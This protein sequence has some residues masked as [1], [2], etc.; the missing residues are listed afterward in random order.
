[1]IMPAT[2]NIVGQKPQEK[3]AMILPLEAKPFLLAATCRLIGVLVSSAADQ[4]GSY[5]GAGYPLSS[6]AMLIM[7]PRGPIFARPSRSATPTATSSVGI[8]ATPNIR[9]GE[10]AQNSASQSLNARMQANWNSLSGIMYM[11]S[12]RLV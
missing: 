4:S 10:A 11:V 2:V 3:S 9:F 7:A 8:I 12:P 6:C 1:K 5:F